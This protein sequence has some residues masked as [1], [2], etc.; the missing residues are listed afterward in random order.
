[1]T[2]NERFGL[3]FENKFGHRQTEGKNLVWVG[4]MERK[5]AKLLMTTFSYR[6]S[7]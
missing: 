7:S 3:V 1:M 2:E 4:E 6:S 5:L